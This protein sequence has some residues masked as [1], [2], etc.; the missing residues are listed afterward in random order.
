VLGNVL[1]CGAGGGGQGGKGGLETRCF[2]GH[3][4]GLNW[5]ILTRK[6]A[7]EALEGRFVLVSAMVLLVIWVHV[8]SPLDVDLGDTCLT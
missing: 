7:R 2:W 5:F 1:P 3:Q 8:G 4:V 6:Q